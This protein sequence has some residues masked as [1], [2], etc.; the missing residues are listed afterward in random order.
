MNTYRIN[1]IGPNGYLA[2]SEVA[3]CANDEAVVQKAL[4]EANG[5]VIE[6]WDHNALSR[7]FPVRL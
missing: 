4:G 3:E 2:R 6:I 1:T 7:G 5:S